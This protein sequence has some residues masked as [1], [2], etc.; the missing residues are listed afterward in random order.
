MAPP[1]SICPV[2]PRAACDLPSKKY[3]EL[4]LKE[5]NCLIFF[6]SRKFRFRMSQLYQTKTGFDYYKKQTVQKSR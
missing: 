4:H 5:V 1:M 2:Y 6:L 3:Q